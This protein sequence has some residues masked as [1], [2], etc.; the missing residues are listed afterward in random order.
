VFD[1]RARRTGRVQ[2]LQQTADYLARVALDGRA[3]FRISAG[4]SVSA[5]ACAG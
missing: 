1:L 2:L 5:A 4:T 3:A